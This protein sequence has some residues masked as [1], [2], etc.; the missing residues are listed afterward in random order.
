MSCAI[1]QKLGKLYPLTQWKSGGRGAK[2]QRWGVG[3]R[4]YRF[5]PQLPFK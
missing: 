4:N 2:K 3:D 5:A 1:S